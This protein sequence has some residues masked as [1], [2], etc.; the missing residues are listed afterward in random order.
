MNVMSQ[1]SLTALKMIVKVMVPDC[2]T[3][4]CSDTD[5]DHAKQMST[6]S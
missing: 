1:P 2:C 5:R 4:D 3:S 6:V